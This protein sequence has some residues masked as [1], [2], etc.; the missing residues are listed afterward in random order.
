MSMDSLN[1]WIQLAWVPVL[2]FHLLATGW[3]GFI[4]R[5]DDDAFKV[6]KGNW[7]CDN[8][9]LSIKS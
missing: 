9:Y 8:A 7:F 3:I 4:F 6:F 1:E 2:G 5:N